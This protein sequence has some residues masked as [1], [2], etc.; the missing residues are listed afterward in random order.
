MDQSK[1]LHNLSEVADLIGMLED[2]T[3]S[4]SPEKLSPASWAGLKITLKNIR[5]NIISSRDTLASEMISK[6]K[7]VYSS[8]QRQ[9][10]QQEASPD[11]AQEL[12]QEAQSEEAPRLQVRRTDLRTSLE[13]LVDR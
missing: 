13:R 8:E 11:K 7:A 1:A 3:N 10:M 9:N 4:A 2:L 12:G 5:T 6:S